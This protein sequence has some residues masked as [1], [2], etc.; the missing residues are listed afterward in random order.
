MSPLNCTGQS[1]VRHPFTV[2]GFAPQEVS[3]QLDQE[4]I[5]VGGLSSLAESARRSV[6]PAGG[7]RLSQGSFNVGHCHVAEYDPVGLP[8]ECCRSVAQ[9]PADLSWQSCN[10][11][12]E[13]KSFTRE[14]PHR[15]PDLNQIL[16]AY[17][18]ELVDCD[19]QPGASF[20]EPPEEIRTDVLPG[21]ADAD[22]E[23][24]L[25]QPTYRH[26]QP[27]GKT[28]RRSLGD[29]L[30]SMPACKVLSH[31]EHDRL[32]DA[33]GARDDRPA[34]MRPGAATQRLVEVIEQAG[35]ANDL[36]WHRPGGGSER[37]LQEYLCPLH[38][39]L[40]S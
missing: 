33:A 23:A 32:S 34:A 6:K 18:V 35:T 27:P 39:G 38:L 2:L 29:D 12:G 5:T 20:P 28:D 13:G 24:L 40:T 31:A 10:H 16:L 7:E 3:D 4:G 15:S 11:Q 1:G 26:A 36:R 19:E 17:G 22:T 30:P 25:R 21:T 37:V 14:G 9:E 8:Q